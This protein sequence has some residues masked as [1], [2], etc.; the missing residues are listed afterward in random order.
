LRDTSREKP[1]KA[2]LLDGLF[3]EK[4]FWPNAYGVSFIELTRS[5]SN[6][7]NNENDKVLPPLPRTSR[8]QSIKLRNLSGLPELPK[9]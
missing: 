1:G 5:L 3:S 8:C 4:A 2:G 9:L 7:R 6:I